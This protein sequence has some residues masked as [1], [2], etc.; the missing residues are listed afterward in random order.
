MSVYLL[1]ELARFIPGKGWIRIAKR[2]QT[3]CHGPRTV[4]VDTMPAIGTYTKA[5]HK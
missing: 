5:R 1:R 3:P 4:K 2:T